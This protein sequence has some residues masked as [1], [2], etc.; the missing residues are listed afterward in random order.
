MKKVTKI[1][2]IIALCGVSVIALNACQ[3][4]TDATQEFN[5]YEE[6][7]STEAQVS[8]APSVC[9]GACYQVKN[10][11]I[12]TPSEIKVDEVAAP[13]QQEILPYVDDLS[14][15]NGAIGQV[16]VA[17]QRTTSCNVA[18]GSGVMAK[19]PACAGIVPVESINIETP[20]RC[21]I[22][23]DKNII[24][25]VVLGKNAFQMKRL[26]GSN[27]LPRFEVNGYTFK[28]VPLDLAIQNLVSEAGIRVYS[29]DGLF[30][31]VSGDNL[32][33]ELS[34]VLDELTA[35]GDVY[36]R[37]DAAKKQL[38]LSRWGRFVLSVPGGRVGMY[39]VLDALRGANITNVQ[40]DFGTNEI[41]MRIK[42]DKYQTIKK[43]TDTILESPNLVLFDIRVYRLVKKDRTCAVDWQSLLN[44]MGMSRVKTSVN[45]IMGR[46]LTMD[47][48]KNSSVIDALR[49]YGSVS[50]VAEGEAVM[51]DGWKVR[52]DI[53][54]CVKNNSPE[55]QLSM[56]LQSNM[57]GSNRVESNISLDTDAGEVTSFHTMYNV[58]D[59][60]NMIGISGAALNAGADN[61]VE[62]VIVMTPRLVKLVK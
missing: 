39:A 31:E 15:V 22:P 33:G 29:D 55:Q 13:K 50:V 35:A 62:Y 17:A 52:Y 10:G 44:R 8:A 61:G 23:A 53:G 41:Y 7:T 18:G 45:G 16:P 28:N 56:V 51:P 38:I 37:Y 27:E 11:Q 54:Q 40:P 24:S 49:Q 21:Q 43:L 19:N 34:V 6:N 42:K 30:P 58:G 4:D 57:L 14:L 32:R 60:L 2:S 3:S 59:S 25:S 1:I 9:T 36:Y 12:V 46:V 48:Q 47:Q 5:V 26:D 20:V